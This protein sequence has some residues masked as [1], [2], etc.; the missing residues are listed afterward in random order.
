MSSIKKIKIAFFLPSFRGGGSEN[1]FVDLANS[2]C[3]MN[4]YSIKFF[5]VD[6]TGPLVK[7]IDKNIEIID[8]KQKSVF[9]SL[10]KLVK[11]IRSKKPD[12]VISSMTHCNLTL[13]IAKLL[14][15]IKVKLILRECSSIDHMF[16]LSFKRP[17]SFNKI[18]IKFLYKK[19]DSIVSNSQDLAED[20]VK[21]FKLNNIITIHN[22]YDIDYI[23]ELSKEKIDLNFQKI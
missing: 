13:V 10:L 21:K 22:G 4:D 1:I 17:K 3:R 7:K 12:I 15:L 9:K 14:S 23:R 5:V 19:A 2:I 16:P 11:F 18:L 6:L 8:F 20:L